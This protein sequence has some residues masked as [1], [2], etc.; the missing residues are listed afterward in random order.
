LFSAASERFSRIWPT[1]KALGS[2][3]NR[4]DHEAA[5]VEW[6][7]QFFANFI[8]TMVVSVYTYGIGFQVRNWLKI[9]HMNK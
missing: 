1:V 5:A 4:T 3:P 9:F 7:E 6:T 8:D 2:D